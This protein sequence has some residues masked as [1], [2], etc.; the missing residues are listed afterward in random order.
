MVSEKQQSKSQPSF[1]FILEIKKVSLEKGR[2][3]FDSEN[4]K[5]IMAFSQ[6]PYRIFYN[7]SLDD[8]IGLWHSGDNNFSVDPPNAVI[9]SNDLEANIYI[10]SALHI[11]GGKVVISIKPEREIIKKI[12]LYDVVLTIDD[13]RFQKR[14]LHPLVCPV[15][16]GSLDWLNCYISK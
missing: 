11:Q 13:Y 14:V 1:M 15:I 8:F 3:I 5:K 7:M 6:A 9:S 2:L 12:T 4:I 16:D 10:L